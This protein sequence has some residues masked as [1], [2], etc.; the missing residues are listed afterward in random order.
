MLR[1]QR[2]SAIL[3]DVL[4]VFAADDEASLWFLKGLSG[5]R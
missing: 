4:G 2:P 5:Y 1:I 3:F